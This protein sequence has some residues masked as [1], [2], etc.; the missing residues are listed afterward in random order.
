MV[1]PARQQGFS[2]IEILLV[3]VLLTVI[4]GLVVPNIIGNRERAN[5]NATKAQIQRLSMAIDNY[6]LD[7]GTPPERLEDLV[8]KPADAA[9]WVGPYAKAQ[10][11]KDPWQGDIQY[12]Y[13]GEHGE[14]DLYSYGADK[15]QGGEGKGADITSWDEIE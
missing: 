5:Q 3:L 6:Y 8:K 15:T 13:P 4:A 14:Y 1:L 2:L 7:N 10:T 11:L 9:N 12:Q